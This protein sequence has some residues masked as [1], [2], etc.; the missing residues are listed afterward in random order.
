MCCFLLVYL[1]LNSEQFKISFVCYICELLLSLLP[2]L[3]LAPVQRGLGSDSNDC[4]YRSQLHRGSGKD[5]TCVPTGTISGGQVAARSKS[6]GR[7][8]GVRISWMRGQFL[9]SQ[10]LCLIPT[11]GNTTAH[12]RKETVCK[13]PLS[14]NEKKK[15][16]KPK[17]KQK[18]FWLPQSPL[19]AEAARD[20][21]STLKSG[22]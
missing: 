7:K 1:C 17:I 19:I 20:A 2:S 22:L 9:M 12:R 14:R 8:H 5:G 15:K 4:S 3:K 21:T 13:V 11:Q 6:E 10:N 18:Y 16:K